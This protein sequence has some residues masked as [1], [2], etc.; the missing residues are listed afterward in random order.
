VGGDLLL[1]YE[2]VAKRIANIRFDYGLRPRRLQ[3]IRNPPASRVPPY[4]ST[5]SFLLLLR[6][7]THFN[8]DFVRGVCK[9]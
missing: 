8:A 9:L 4:N 1:G 7:Q 2:Q 3:I 5:L 6:E